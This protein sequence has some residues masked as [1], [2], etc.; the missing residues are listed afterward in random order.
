MITLKIVYIMLTLS[1]A[2]L[3][4]LAGGADLGD[5]IGMVAAFGQGGGDDGGGEWG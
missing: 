3:A 4:P 1:L 5:S 2:L